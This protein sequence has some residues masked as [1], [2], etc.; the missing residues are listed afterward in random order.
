MSNSLGIAGVTA[1]IRDML[2]NR[3]ASDPVASVIGS[4]TVSAGAPDR[5]DLSQST[6]PNQVNI[7]LY[8]VTRNP[9]LANVDLP[10]RN[11]EGQRIK[12]PPLALDLH[13]LISVYGAQSYYSEILLGE[14]VQEFH[15]RPVPNRQI[16]HQALNPVSPPVGFPSEIAGSGLSEQIERIRITPEIMNNE[17]ISKLWSALQARYRTTV[18]YMVSTVIIESEAPSRPS[19]PVYRR[20]GYSFNQA[21]PVIRSVQTTD[22]FAAPILAGSSL[23]ITGLHFGG[24]NI[25]LMLQEQD[26][27]AH[28]TDRSDTVITLTLPDPLPSGICSGINAFQVVKQELISEPEAL[29]NVSVSNPAP[30]ILQ[31][32]LQGVVPSIDSSSV[33]N[34]I[35]YQT[36]SLQVTFAPAAT[37]SQKIALLLNPLDP[38]AS[39]V[40]AYRL[41]VP[42]GNGISDPSTET[43]TVTVP[44]SNIASTTYMV[45]IEIDGAVSQLTI[46][47]SGQFNGPTVVL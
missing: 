31:P 17:E 7:Y 18:A 5:V 11:S 4:V 30:F 47:G 8:Q 29:R 34:S 9:G 35:T 33:I 32:Q 43:G 42:D 25:L 15:E 24:T 44:F 36:G 46:D 41:K 23:V 28:I 10:S 39:G 22:G 40:R 21:A 6:D 26:F 20:L 45:R 14:I 27:S 16:I 19:L 38:S 3:F 1:V 2:I 13:F 37:K 12:S